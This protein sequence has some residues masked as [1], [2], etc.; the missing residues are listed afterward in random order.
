MADTV[1]PGHLAPTPE[2]RRVA[3][4]QFERANEVLL[5][6][7]YDYALRLLLDCCKL[8]PANLIYR[9]AL[10]QAQKARHNNNL[11][12]GRLAFLTTLPARLRM[13]A[14]RAARDHRKLLEVA[15]RILV[16][17]PWDVGTQLAM[18]ESFQALNLTDQAIWTLEQARLNEPNHLQV[19]RT[20]AR[21]YEKRGNFKQAMALWALVRKADPGDLE[22]Y[23]KAKDLAARDTIVRGGYV[24]ALVKRS[25]EETQGED[26]R[27]PTPLDRTREG[28]APPVDRVAREASPWLQRIRQQPSDVDAYLR[29]AAIYRRADRLD[30]AR[31][32]LTQGLAKT[33]NHFELQTELAEMEIEPFRQNLALTEEKLRNQ[34]DDE[35]LRRI[36]A[37]LLKEINTRELYLYGQ[38]AERFPTELSHRYELGLR[39]LRAAQLDEAIRELQAARA[40][41]QYQVRALYYLGHCFKGRNNWRLARRNFEEA[42]GHLGDGDEALRKEILFQLAQ[43]SAEAGDFARAVEHGT[44]LANLDFWYRDVGKLLDAWQSELAGGED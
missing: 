40:D 31:D 29:A 9:Q 26:N 44:E 24:E 13:R 18:A 22:A 10:R 23:D 30:E 35:G 37:K 27:E 1:S 4:G 34:P 5:A 15:E 42:L 12:G 17:N 20:L 43:G 7:N 19:N 6:H 28:P 39:L 25:G 14:A 36:R 33:G 16:R 21:L 41:P 11:R 32:L 38:K 2:Q 8:D 3:A